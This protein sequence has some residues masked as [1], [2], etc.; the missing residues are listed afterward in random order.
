MTKSFKLKAVAAV[1][2][3][4]AALVASAPASAYVYSVSQLQIA[5]LD[6]S[7]FKTGTTTD[8]SAASNYTFNLSNN[9]TFTP[10]GGSTV[11][12]SGNKGCAG[13]VA[14]GTTTCNNAGGAVLDAPVANAPGLTAARA[15]NNFAILG[16]S[17]STSY[18]NADS[19]ITTAKLV[20]GGKTNT[21]QIAESLL[22]VNG[23][24]SAN[25]LVK[26][27]TT[28][29]TTLSFQ[30]VTDL[31]V[32]FDALLNLKGS[33][34]DMLNGV[35]TSA[36]GANV[37]ISLTQ[38]Q[39]GGKSWTWS[40]D[41]TAGQGCLAASAGSIAGT[42]CAVTANGGNLNVTDSVSSTPDSFDDSFASFKNFGLKIAGLGA[43]TYSLSLQATTTTNVDRL[44]VPEP[45][46]LA[47]VGFA[48]A[49]LGFV[50]K[51]RSRKQ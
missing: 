8:V 47:L 23:Q 31:V 6:V 11:S 19:Q 15:E 27:T 42:T 16:P 30:G 50:G 4:F 10:D 33:I 40:P 38:N 34:A 37:S 5:N 43:G 18:S 17:S 45:G 46:S 35:Y 51:R 28:L 48:L 36:G 26:S 39:S 22:N 2:G 41:G 29:V 32:N 3:A 13:N 20:T 21:T 9:A 44:F 25:T 12:Q 24:A 49:G 7:V 1:A 14:A